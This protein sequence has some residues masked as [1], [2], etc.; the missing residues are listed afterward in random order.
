MNAL[1][2]EILINR[3]LLWL[4]LAYHSVNARPDGCVWIMDVCLAVWCIASAWR[5]AE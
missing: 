5:A 3:A 1:R 4:V 2:S